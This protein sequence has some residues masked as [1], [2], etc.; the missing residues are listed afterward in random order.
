MNH[1]GNGRSYTEYYETVW[2][3]DDRLTPKS[4]GFAGALVCVAYTKG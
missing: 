4:P 2:H 1:T 3:S